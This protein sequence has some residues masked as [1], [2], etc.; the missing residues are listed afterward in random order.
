MQ[1]LFYGVFSAW[2]L[3]SKSPERR[4]RDEFDWKDTGHLLRVPAIAAIFDQ[5]GTGS[6]TLRRLALTEPL[7]WA[8][9]ALNRVERGPFFAPFAEDE[10]VQY[11]YEPFLEA[12]DPELRKQLGVW[13]TP[14]EVV[15][16]MVGRVHQVLKDEFN[17]APGR[18]GRCRRLRT[19]SLLRQ[20][21][22]I[23][24]QVLNHRSQVLQEQG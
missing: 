15:K 13:Y 23:W 4:A 21:A 8:G 2:V 17:L 22:R 10:A 16:Y 12:F 18:A 14:P 6:A 5:V 11:F 24:Y 19:R 7:E 20:P 9:T 3:W 1:T